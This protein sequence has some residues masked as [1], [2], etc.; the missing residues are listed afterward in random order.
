[1]KLTSL[2]LSLMLASGVLAAPVPPPPSGVG[3]NT[4]SLTLDSPA[5]DD[6]APGTMGKVND[7]LKGV[8]PPTGEAA[9]PPT[10]TAQK[11]AEG[12]PNAANGLHRRITPED[13][14]GV[15]QE[16]IDAAIADA[17]SGAFIKRTDVPPQVGGAVA[18]TD[19]TINEVKKDRPNGISTLPVGKRTAGPPALSHAGI[20]D[21]INEEIAR[22][23]GR[24]GKR[25]PDG[26]VDLN[27]L[28]GAL[29]PGEVANGNGGASGPD[30]VGAVTSGFTRR[31]S[32]EKCVTSGEIKE[33]VDC[34]V[35]GVNPNDIN[36]LNEVPKSA[37]SGPTTGSPEFA[38]VSSPAS[39]LANG[40]TGG[41]PKAGDATKIAGDAT[42][43]A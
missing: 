38:G 11:A 29:K 18:I 12:G 42:K 2:L 1:M 31:E 5:V 37:T 32:P 20:N 22:A 23:S 7:G 9:D 30:I 33:G 26:P 3:L 41:V 14:A 16:G 6:R 21:A 27:V 25:S 35:A 34:V 19:G 4:D 24:S 28:S 39:G 43:G 17:L 8:K 10:A 36:H 13:A 15:D 40:A